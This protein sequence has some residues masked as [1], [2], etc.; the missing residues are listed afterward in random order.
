[1]YWE[2]FVAFNYECLPRHVC[3]YQPINSS[4]D[5]GF[6]ALRLTFAN[7]NDTDSYTLLNIETPFLLKVMDTQWCIAL[8]TNGNPRHPSL[9]GSSIIFVPSGLFHY[10]YMS[11]LTFTVIMP[12]ALE[13][14]G[15]YG[16]VDDLWPLL[17]TWFNFN[18]SMDK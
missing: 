3:D 14:P 11:L 13:N 18:P 2:W 10:H 6:G 9:N 12:T 15:G 4:H 17:L 1:M 16:K 7:L 5:D 8:V